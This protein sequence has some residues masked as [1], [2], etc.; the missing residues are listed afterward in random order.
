MIP[1]PLSSNYG[2]RHCENIIRL[3][4]PDI[5]ICDSDHFAYDNRYNIENRTISH[6]F[7]KSIPE[8]GI[9]DICVILCTSGTTGTPKGAMITENGL[10]SNVGDIAQY[11]RLQRGETTVIAR[12]LY[13]CAV[14][15]G[16]FLISLYS[17]SS[18]YFADVAYNP[19]LLFSTILE[20]RASTLGGTPTL[21]Q[22]LSLLASKSDVLHSVK[23]IAISGECMTEEAARRIRSGFPKTDIYNVYGLTEASPRVSYLDAGLFD[24]YPEFVGTPLA[25]VSVK[26]VDENGIEVADGREGIIQ[27]RGPNVMKGY[28]GD[29]CLTSRTI[30]DGW[31]NTGDIG[32]RKGANLLRILGRA[33]DMI[34]KAGMNIYPAEIENA[35]KCHKAILDVL[36][37]GIPSFAGQEIAIN[38]VLTEEYSHFSIR[39]LFEVCGEVLPPYMLPSKINIV[40]SLEKNAS[41]K[42]VRPRFV[43]C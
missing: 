36:A 3:V 2:L 42:V 22:Q 21:F 12:P 25:S 23:R 18:I 17:G 37:Y 39:E 28:Y 14:L 32:V 33:D 30:V 35:L 31:L 19:Y 29:P 16:E 1:I 41:G 20:R 9:E 34:I 5:I 15:T 26:L 38:A 13:H 10:V 6:P 27:V 24:D 7:S 4:K 40:A 8:E 11:F 43:Q